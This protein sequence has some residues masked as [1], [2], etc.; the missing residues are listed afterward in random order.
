MTAKCKCYSVL[1][2]G[3]RKGFSSFGGVKTN[4]K[5]KHEKENSFLHL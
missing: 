5:Q 2:S 1:E 3:P 4:P